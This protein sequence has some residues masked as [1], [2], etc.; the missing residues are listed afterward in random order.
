MIIDIEKI[1][2]EAIKN[3]SLLEEHIDTNI[4]ELNQRLPMFSYLDQIRTALNLMLINIKEMTNLKEKIEISEKLT[5][6]FYEIQKITNQSNRI[7]EILIR[8]N[9]NKYGK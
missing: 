6:I 4:Y 7:E 9:K 2:G 1:L 5:V 3:T 8:R